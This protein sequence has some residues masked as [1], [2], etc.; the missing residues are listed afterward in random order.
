MPTLNEHK[1]KH[2]T[3]ANHIKQDLEP[4]AHCPQTQKELAW[5][6]GRLREGQLELK[7]MKL[8]FFLSLKQNKSKLQLSLKTTTSDGKLQRK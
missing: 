4:F 6:P 1:Q 8:G 3:Q 2:E 5:G 7:I